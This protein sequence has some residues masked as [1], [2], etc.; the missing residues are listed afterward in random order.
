MEWVIETINPGKILPEGVVQEL[1]GE[2]GAVG[3]DECTALRIN[4]EGLEV[5]LQ[6]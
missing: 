5:W 1:R 3:P 6:L 2:V 4:R